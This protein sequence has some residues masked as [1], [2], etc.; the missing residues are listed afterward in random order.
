MKKAKLQTLFRLSR[1][2]DCEFLQYI[3]R[4]FSISQ[5]LC[6]WPRLEWIIQNISCLCNYSRQSDICGTCLLT[7]FLSTFSYFLCVFVDLYLHWNKCRGDA[8]APIYQPITG[9]CH[10][11]DCIQLVKKSWKNVS[12]CNSYCVK[13]MSCIEF[14]AFRVNTITHKLKNKR[15]YFF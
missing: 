8:N 9:I 13:K 12:H 1:L 3:S 10:K 14:R 2:W 4:L 11:V 7:F 5:K 6:W 15:C